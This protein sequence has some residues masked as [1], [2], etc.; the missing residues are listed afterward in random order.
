M[1]RNG[2]PRKVI[3]RVVLMIAITVS[4]LGGGPQT[5]NASR[6]EP[7]ETL[8]AAPGVAP[9]PSGLT[10]LQGDFV[11]VSMNE[12]GDPVPFRLVLNTIPSATQ[13]AIQWAINR[14][15][16]HGI[17]SVEGTGNAAAVFFQPE[18]D[19][20]GEDSFEVR[21]H[22]QDGESDSA[23]VQ[24]KILP[25]PR[26]AAMA[27]LLPSAPPLEEMLSQV[28]DRQG[29]VAQVAA[30]YFVVDITRN[31]VT[32]VNWP[33]G[34]SVTMTV[35]DPSNGVGVDYSNTQPVTGAEGS[36]GLKFQPA[37]FTLAVGQVVTLSDGAITTSHTVTSLSITLTD[38][39]ADTVSGTGVAGNILDVLVCYTGPCNVV[40]TTVAAGGTW[41]AD[42]Y[43]QTVPYD[44]RPGANGGAFWWDAGGNATLY[45]WAI[46]T[47]RI[48]VDITWKMIGGYNWKAGGALTLSIDDPSTGVGAD[49]TETKSISSN[50]SST[51][52]MFW[53][54]NFN[55]KPGEI[56][57]MSDGITR[58][59]YTIVP[60]AITSVD[61][62]ADQVYG[63]ALPGSQVDN[64]ASIDD[65]FYVPRTVTAGV[66]GNWMA[67]FSTGGTVVDIR[68]GAWGMAEQYD[69]DSNSTDVPWYVPRPKVTV[70][71]TDNEVVVFD[72]PFGSL[73]TLAIDD[74][75]NGAGTD[76]TAQRYVNGGIP[77]ASVVSF[78]I[79]GLTL[80]PG[81]VLTLS[82]SLPTQ[83]FTIS[84]DITGV[85]VA[86]NNV[87][88]VA[89][90][91]SL[92]ILYD[93]VAEYTETTADQNGDWFAHL[94]HTDI[95]PGTSG[96]VIMKNTNGDSIRSIWH[97]LKPRIDVYP[98][99]NLVEGID[100]TPGETVSLSIDDPS[101]GAGSDYTAS[102]VV[103]GTAFDSKVDF[104]TGGFLL[105]PRQVV[106]LS[107]GVH[108]STHTITDIAI[109]H[110]SQ[111]NDTVSGTADP[112]SA[113]QVWACLYHHCTTRDL[114]A[115]ADGSWL[116]NYA[117]PLYCDIQSGADGRAFQKDADGNTS[118][119][120]WQTMKMYFYLYLS[121]NF[122]VGY[123]WPVGQ[124][125]T[126]TINDPSN[127]PGVDYTTTASPEGQVGSDVT[128][129]RFYIADSFKLRNGQGISLTNGT[130]TQTTTISLK[131]N[132]VDNGIDTISGTA[133]PETPVQAQISTSGYFERF[134]RTDSSGHWSVV[135]SSG[136][137]V[138]DIIPGNIGYINAWD[139]GGNM[140]RMMWLAIP[141]LTSVTPSYFMAGTPGAS[142]EVYGGGF[143]SHFIVRWNGEDL[144]TTYVSTSHLHAIV[145]ASFLA[146][147]GAAVV[148][149]VDPERTEASAFAVSNGVTI[150]IRSPLVISGNAGAPGVSLKYTDVISRIARTDRSGN[151]SFTV[152]YGW[153]G[154]VTPES[155]GYIFTP[156]NR[157]YTNVI[158]DTPGQN[159]TATPAFSISGAIGTPGVTLTYTVGGIASSTSTDKNGN[160]AITVPR[161]WSGTVVP[162]MKCGGLNSISR[163]YFTPSSRMYSNVQVDFG[164]QNYVL[165][166]V[167]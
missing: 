33:A 34:D 80:K 61:Q 122:V 4:L 32:G 153:S 110:V 99:R 8:E 45:F 167:R 156:R 60:L 133:A 89:E 128:Y 151:Y 92:I 30:P 149:A 64:Y 84:L 18:Q 121:G 131:I 50:E 22:N 165:K 51:W 112:G 105:K 83:I 136:G 163:C 95:V 16:E 139:D 1:S 116:A 114:V 31:V 57:T 23:L 109:I 117:V 3:W 157:V 93:N 15:P 140:S 19:Y 77:T 164:R 146:S 166:I 78:L 87:S 68:P 24:V 42:F 125:V 154:I 113:V 86:N 79:D 7:V 142:I 63:T 143:T 71:L 118:I 27:S 126:L 115:G 29:V 100:W 65:L 26:S 145:K 158:A 74:P 111:V 62:A 108:T 20:V 127:G 10:I 59:V 72:W 138:V 155:I 13:K 53:L 46:P 85:D 11:S 104:N 58:Q 144:P 67:D 2:Q 43:A 5:A 69:Q 91:R 41:L 90:P 55:F 75:S 162:S 35:D 102:A 28:P 6:Q 9:T 134:A 135:F 96:N 36:T 147:R 49:Y 129:S 66:D 119:I 44:V 150:Y 52:C 81:Q 148:S 82:G 73:V 98:T 152:S 160:Y 106:T 54:G 88:G 101:N 56:I 94:S 132:T 25:S 40:E 159:Y 47:V 70:S 103:G 97:A 39:A 123:N 130:D 161:G 141:P 38:L 14:L 76:Y 12:N 17:A 120:P 37:G 137:P 21:A 107:N 48:D 124:P